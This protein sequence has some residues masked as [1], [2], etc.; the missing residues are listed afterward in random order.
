[1]PPDFLNF[2]NERKNKKSE[3]SKEPIE[4]KEKVPEMD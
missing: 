2:I 4:E 3:T 1:L